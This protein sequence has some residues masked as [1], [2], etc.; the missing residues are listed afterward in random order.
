[1]GSW[2]WN[3]RKAIA[4]GTTAVP[5]FGV[6]R[7]HFA[8]S[9]ENVR[10]LIHPDDWDG[11]QI[12]IE[13]LFKD[14]QPTQNEFR[15]KRPNGE[16]RWC[17]GTAARVLIPP[18]R[19]ADQRRDGGHHRAQASR[20]ASD[21]AGPRGRSPRQECACR[22][23]IDCPA[24]PRQHHRGI[25][26]RS[27]RPHPLAVTRHTILSL[28]RWQ[29]AD[30]SGLV[31]EELAPYRSVDARKVTTSGPNVSLWPAAAQCLA[32]ALHELVTNAAK[33]GALSSDTG[34]VELE[35]STASWKSCAALDRERR[36]AELGPL[37]TWL[38]HAHHQGQHRR[39]ACRR[40]GI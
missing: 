29:G 37:G 10:A 19:R 23:A 38:W 18:A 20:R 40:D 28:S 33:Y 7:Q 24:D 17:L 12:A 30:L 2:D 11:L 34:R 32:L 4:S 9:A 35:W 1:M 36:A 3:E 25:H 14:R 39:A 26:N 15:V 22:R 5:I 8:V 31:E 27:R 6:D 21:P 16:V 13:R